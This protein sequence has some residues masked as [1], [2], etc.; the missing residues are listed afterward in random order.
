LIV[1]ILRPLAPV[2]APVFALTLLG[3]GNSGCGSSSRAKAQAESN[4]PKRL[5]FASGSGTFVNALADLDDEILSTR[6]RAD[7]QPMSW[8]TL[9]RVAGL[10]LRRAK[11]S[12]DY[13]DYTKAEQALVEAFERAPEGAGP[14][15][16]R[17]A[18][19]SSMHRVDR[20]QADLDRMAASI[21]ID[22]PT[23]SGLAG[24][25]GD[26]AMQRGDYEQAAEHV[27]KA[28]ELHRNLN[29]LS[30][31][32]LLLW[33][34]GDYEGAETLYLEALDTIV[35]PADNLDAAAWIHLQ[36]GLMDLDRGRY[37]DAFGHYQ[38]GAE[39]LP[40]W[41]LLEEHIAEICVLTGRTEQATEL[42]EAIVERTNKGEFMDALAELAQARGD[43]VGAQRWIERSRERF[44]AELIKWPE[45]SY[46]HALGHF[47]AFGP[48]PRALALAE[49]NHALRPNVEAKRDLATAR[50][51]VDDVAGAKTVIDEALATPVKRAD[52]LWV[53]AEVYAKSG[54]EAEAT[55]LRSAATAINPNIASE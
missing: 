36:L 12:G 9:E 8:L 31:Q 14:V 52:V 34:R 50:L 23:A 20:V 43:E 11:L 48:A 17:A 44:E 24:M 40:G 26:L 38:A 37:D 42:Y 29:T 10:Y 22:D 19:N 1:S 55:K 54:D 35:R 21:L 15:M 6:Q 53:A 30:R 39:L 2:L 25:R 49:A 32:A 16:T 33:Q 3:C 45:A 13:D 18:L 46:G 4:E 47:L 5:Q 41:W 27:G 51:G 28:L 7:A